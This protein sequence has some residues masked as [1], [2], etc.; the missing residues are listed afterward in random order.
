MS[1]WTKEMQIWNAEIKAGIAGEKK[2]SW[3]RDV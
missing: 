1:F 3:L 2:D